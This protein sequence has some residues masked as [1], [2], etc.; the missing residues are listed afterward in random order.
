MGGWMVP[1]DAA[2]GGSCGGVILLFYSLFTYPAALLSLFSFGPTCRHRCCHRQNGRLAIGRL[3]V[4]CEQVKELNFQGYEVI[5][6]ASR[7]VGVEAEAQ[8][9]KAH[10]QQFRRS[11]EPIVRPG[12]EGMRCRRPEWPHGYLR[13]TD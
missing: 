11:A 2:W 6:V 3:G 7:A 1:C 5:L 10:Q 4:L 9:R 12:W 8:V 13:Y